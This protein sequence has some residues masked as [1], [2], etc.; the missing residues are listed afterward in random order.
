MLGIS[1]IFVGIA[2]V[3]NGVCRLCK[4]DAKSTAIINI[5]TG[6]VIVVGNFILI[7]G[8][9]TMADYTNI[10]S[11]FLFGFTYL[12]IAANLLFKLDLRPFAWFSLFVAIYAIVMGTLAFVDGTW[13]YGAL[14]VAWAILWLEGFVEIVFNVKTLTKIFPY[15]SIVEGVLAAF[16]PAILILLSIV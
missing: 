7:G 2:L 14:W 1:L 3:S 5:I 12:F 10:V 6:L 15:L 11:G 9:E 4:V 16:I 13:F 8:A